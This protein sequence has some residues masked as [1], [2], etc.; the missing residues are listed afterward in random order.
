VGLQ[1]RHACE[2]RAFFVFSLFKRASQ[3]ATTSPT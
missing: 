1:L 2:E 3:L